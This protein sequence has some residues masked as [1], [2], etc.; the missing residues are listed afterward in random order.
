MKRL[1][2]LAV[3]IVAVLAACTSNG[4]LQ[5]FIENANVELAGMKVDGGG[6]CDGITLEDNTV[7]YSYTYP[8]SEAPAEYFDTQSN[9]YRMMDELFASTVK[10]E[11]AA[12]PELYKAI[13]DANASLRIDLH[14]D[15]GTVTF[16]VNP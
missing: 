4:K 5:Q 1:S 15:N 3:A 8:G 14:Y 10:R 12:D 16:N 7:V 9:E 11:I 6:V 13:T 2:L